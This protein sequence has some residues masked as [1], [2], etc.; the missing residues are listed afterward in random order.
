MHGRIG[1]HGCVERLSVPLVRS[2]SRVHVLYHSTH[3]SILRLDLYNLGFTS[4]PA[5]FPSVVHNLLIPKLR[6]LSTSARPLP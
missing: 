2:R 4:F 6:F 1:G 5:P 3:P